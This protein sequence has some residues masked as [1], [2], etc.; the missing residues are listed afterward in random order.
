MNSF[1]SFLSGKQ[2]PIK[3]SVISRADMERGYQKHPSLAAYLPWRDVDEKNKVFLLEDNRSLAVGFEITPLPCEA[4]P[5]AMME[6]ISQAFK[7]SLQNAIPQEK[8]HPW[9]LQIFVMRNGTLSPV[10]E[11]IQD[12]IDPERRSEPLVQAHLETMRIHLEY[13]SRPS[14]IFMDS[15]VTQH[16]FRGGFWQVYA[17]LYRREMDK[18]DKKNKNNKKRL[19]SGLHE[20]NKRNERNQ[21]LHQQRWED[22]KKISAKLRDQWRA[23]GLGVKRLPPADFYRWMVRLV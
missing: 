10:L 12:S 21:A 7:E 19:P 5:A 16:V 18:K 14:G 20:R 1:F 3:P 6:K 11:K 8:N 9:I 2:Q 22:I 13:V 4:R 23:C 17:F 15:A